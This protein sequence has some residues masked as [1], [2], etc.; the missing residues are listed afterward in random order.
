[1]LALRRKHMLEHICNRYSRL[2]LAQGSRLTALPVPLFE[3]PEEKIQDQ[4][5]QVWELYRPL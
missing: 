1:M 4:D 2:L 5:Y 3:V